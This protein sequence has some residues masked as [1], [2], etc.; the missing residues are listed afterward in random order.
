MCNLGKF[1]V[2]YEGQSD[3][4]VF[5]DT[6]KLTNKTKRVLLINL[7]K[8]NGELCYNSVHE[9]ELDKYDTKKFLYKG[10]PPNGID[11]TPS[12]LVTKKQNLHT[13]IVF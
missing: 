5:L 2:E 11:F 6:A 10:G 8:I 3:I 12:S 4:D 9:Q 1:I 13:K 7:K